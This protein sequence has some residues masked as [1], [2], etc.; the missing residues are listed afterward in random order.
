LLAKVNA[1]KPEGFCAAFGGA[2]GL[3]PGG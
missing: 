2:P 1:A 3:P